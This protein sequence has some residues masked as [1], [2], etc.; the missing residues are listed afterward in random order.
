VVGASSE[1]VVAVLSCEG[2]TVQVGVTAPISAKFRGALVS[3]DSRHRLQTKP[4][5]DGWPS[6]TTRG[7][8]GVI[9]RAQS[10][11]NGRLNVLTG[12]PRFDP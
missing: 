9:D 7:R 4:K 1:M 5:N 10:H 8:S 2:V 11:W 3:A 6:K 12:A